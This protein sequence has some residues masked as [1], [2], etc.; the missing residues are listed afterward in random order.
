MGIVSHHTETI[1]HVQ[2]LEM[3]VNSLEN[4]KWKINNDYY[5]N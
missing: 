4:K 5:D 1:L 3:Q 2:E